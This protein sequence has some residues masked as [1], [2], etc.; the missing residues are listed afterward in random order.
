MRSVKWVLAVCVLLFILT[1]SN[2]ATAELRAGVAKID[3]SPREPVYMAGYDART[4]ASTGVHDP[5]HARV[6]VLDDGARRLAIVTADLCWF[7]TDRVAREAKERFGVGC[8]LTAA[9]HSHAGPDFLFKDHWDS[10]ERA[11]RVL[12]WTEDRA[13]EA[14]GQ[15][16]ANLFPARLAVGA[17]ELPLGYN[18]LV[19]QP[20]GRRVPVFGNPDR[21]PYGPVDPRVGL[22]RVEDAEARTTRALLVNYACH[23]VVLGGRNRQLS[24]DWPGAMAAKIERERPGTICLFAQGGCGNINP[25]FRAV[26]QPEVDYSQVTR[27]GEYLADEVLRTL[28][29]LAP[30][31]GP[32]EVQWR[33]KVQRF[34]NRWSGPPAD[35][36]T[37]TGPIE[38]G[39]ATVLINR[40]V[41]IMAIPGEPLV[42]LQTA[43]KREAPVAFPLFFGYTT[44]G[45]AAWP[46]Y[47]PDIR[48]AAEGGYGA[49][50]RT[51]I[52]VGGGERLVNGALVD[53]YWMNG[54]LRPEPGR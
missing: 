16:V 47:V 6:L 42:A 35:S 24:A 27:M 18:R 29:K 1:A 32:D 46:E 54:M 51:F 53:L 44:V 5:L 26:E 10:V 15:A 17:G 43:F 40:A 45:H 7:P 20:N 22:L 8:T 2:Q 48:S 28:P 50:R 49:D 12:R 3:I 19:M 11:Q 52:E 13:L 38:I 14:I 30:V 41:G 36:W 25:L 39:T 33:A 31:E 9:S 23:A 4:S 21:I 34:E 37:R